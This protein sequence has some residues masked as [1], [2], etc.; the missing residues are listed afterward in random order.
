MDPSKGARTGALKFK[1]PTVHGQGI[2]TESQIGTKEK[3]EGP[4]SDRSK[5]VT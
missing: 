1:W 3:H 5:I 4:G 2:H